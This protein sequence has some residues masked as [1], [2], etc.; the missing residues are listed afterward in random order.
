MRTVLASNNPAKLNELQQLFGGLHIELVSQHQ[1]DVASV[2][3]TGATFVENAIEKARHV[4]AAVRLPAIADDSGLVVEA[5]QGAPGLFSARYAGEGATD[6]ANNA[7]LVSELAGVDQRAAYFYCA[8]VFMKHTDDPAPLVATAAWHGQIIDV[9][10]GSN[11]FGY[12]PHFYLEA[13]GKTSAELSTQ[14][15]HRLSHRG[16]A[17]RKLAEQLRRALAA[18]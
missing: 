8:L 4:S 9:P 1:L 3:E 11:G 2:P 12:D 13:L 14:E 15:K 18:C 17:A 6:Q 7:K 5:L 10:R 16:Q